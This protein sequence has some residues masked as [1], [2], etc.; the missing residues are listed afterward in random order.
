MQNLDRTEF[1]SLVEV[2]IETIRKLYM[3][4]DYFLVTIKLRDAAIERLSK[5][6]TTQEVV[7]KL[8]FEII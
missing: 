7:D 4:K 1:D 6:K 3:F 8:R 5:S 2:P